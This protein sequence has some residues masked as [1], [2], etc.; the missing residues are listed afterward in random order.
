MMRDPRDFTGSLFSSCT[1]TFICNRVACEPRY[2]QPFY[3]SHLIQSICNEFG[4]FSS[5]LV[6]LDDQFDPA[7]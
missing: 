4:P 6:R 5:L 7:V 3:S 2:D 1:P